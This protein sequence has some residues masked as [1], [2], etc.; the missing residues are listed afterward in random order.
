MFLLLRKLVFQ[1]NLCYFN[2]YFSDLTF[3]P[4]QCIILVHI[5]FWYP[6]FLNLF[7]PFCIHSLGSLNNYNV[8]LISMK[9]TIFYL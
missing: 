9:V 7:G 5:K 4:D 8:T 6:I 2:T 3:N 1:Q